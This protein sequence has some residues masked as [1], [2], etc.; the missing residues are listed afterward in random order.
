AKAEE[1]EAGRNGQQCT[2]FGCRPASAAATGAGLKVG[3]VY[4]GPE[5]QA[6]SERCDRRRGH[7]GSEVSRSRN[8]IIARGS[9]A[10]EVDAQQ[11]RAV[12]CDIR[13]ERSNVTG[14]SD[15]VDSGIRQP[16]LR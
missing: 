4:V 6:V 8:G 10:R 3:E 13:A 16:N 7:T 14:E 12:E 15:L 11:G 9:V 1:D 2:G 5:C